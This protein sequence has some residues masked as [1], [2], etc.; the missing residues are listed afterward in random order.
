[1]NDIEQEWLQMTTDEKIKAT[2]M[3]GRETAREI[4]D[5]TQA[6]WGFVTS[7]HCLDG[8]DLARFWSLESLPSWLSECKSKYEL[9][10]NM[11]TTKHEGIFIAKA[12]IVEALAEVLTDAN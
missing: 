9:Q 12:I 4:L 1:M 2:K 10:T 6:F 3:F 8:R 7:V 5:V 11:T